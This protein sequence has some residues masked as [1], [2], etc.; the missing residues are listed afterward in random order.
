MITH[1]NTKKDIVAAQK[2]DKEYPLTPQGHINLSFEVKKELPK[3]TRVAIIG[4]GISGASSAYFLSELF[5]SL[6]AGGEITGDETIKPSMQTPRLTL[7]SY[8]S[9]FSL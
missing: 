4:S 1:L 3:K 5:D 2:E 6:G 7:Y 8:V 9:L